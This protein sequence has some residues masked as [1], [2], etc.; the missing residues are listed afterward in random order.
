VTAIDRV[1]QTMFGKRYMELNDR[2]AR[3]VHEAIEN[4]RNR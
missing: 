3:M 4:S 2:Q 1:A